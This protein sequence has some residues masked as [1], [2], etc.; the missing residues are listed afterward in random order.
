MLLI[1]IQ[2]KL[3]FSRSVVRLLL[4]LPSNTGS[5]SIPEDPAAVLLE[6]EE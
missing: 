6:G 5:A 2:G 3:P 1:V 4:S